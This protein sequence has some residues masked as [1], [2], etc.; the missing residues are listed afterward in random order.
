VVCTSS[1]VLA[2]TVEEAH[3]AATSMYLVQ[4]VN[5]TERGNEQVA[6]RVMKSMNS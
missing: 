4:V 6:S 3:K 2:H 5:F 1:M